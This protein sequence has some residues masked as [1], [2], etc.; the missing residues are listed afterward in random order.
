M[1]LL[2]TL[3][4]TFMAHGRKRGWPLGMITHTWEHSHPGSLAAKTLGMPG[5]RLLRLPC[6]I[7]LEGL[8]Q[9]QPTPMEKARRKSQGKLWLKLSEWKWQHAH[10]EKINKALYLYILVIMPGLYIHYMSNRERDECWGP[11]SL[12]FGPKA[13]GP[14]LWGR[15]D[16]HSTSFEISVPS[17]SNWGKNSCQPHGLRLS[18]SKP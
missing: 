7:S 1:E 9:H 11:S 16:V 15:E 6:P 8:S 14:L 3:I 17:L 12:V 10:A 5:L 2:L 13:F 18:P 4:W